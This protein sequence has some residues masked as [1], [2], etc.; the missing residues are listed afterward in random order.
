MARFI[1]VLLLIAVCFTAFTL[2]TLA[3]F[4]H[5]FA[6]SQQSDDIIQQL[7]A[8]NKEL[9]SNVQELTKQVIALSKKQD[10]VQTSQQAGHTL[11]QD[12]IN[13]QDK[14]SEGTPKSTRSEHQDTKD[15]LG[16]LTQPHKQVFFDLGS[17]Y[18]DTVLLFTG[19]EEKALG[20]VDKMSGYA[21][22]FPGA[23]DIIMYEGHPKYNE[24]LQKVKEKIESLDVYQYGGPYTVYLNNGT[25]IGWED[26]FAEFYFDTNSK[27]VWGSSLYKNAPD[28]DGSKPGSSTKIPIHDLVKKIMYNYKVSDYV[29]VKM[30]IEGAE[31]DLLNELLVRGAFPFIDELYVEFHHHTDI[32][33]RVKWYKGDLGILDKVASK[34]MKIGTWD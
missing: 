9:Q 18:G 19:S 5:I 28:H 4:S 27:E 2:V 34:Q 29:I 13:T 33:N 25:A 20:G 6:P 16:Y 10:A 30:D 14:Q 11:L 12:I 23:W 21:Q 3:N 1:T 22:K 31:F 24:P 32:D 17:N 7:L 15:I 8:T 26:G